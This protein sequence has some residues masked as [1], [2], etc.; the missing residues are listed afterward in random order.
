[1]P[2]KR[3]PLLDLDHTQLLIID[4][5]ERL[6]PHIHNHEACV[7]AAE[8]IIR[9]C[10]A[11]EVPVTLSEQY[12]RGLGPTTPSITAA[13]A[14]AP[15]FEKMTFSCCADHAGRERISTVLRPQ[16]L[17]VGIEAHVCVQQTALDLLAMQMQPFVLADAVSSRRPLDCDTALHRLRHAGAVVTTVEA[18]IFELVRESGTERFKCILPLVK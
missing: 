4:I 17:L 5:Q 9:A 2:E 18:A 12:V 1:M 14:A 13:A 15:R 11:L 7:A 10:T 8:R 6:L 16:V 3:P